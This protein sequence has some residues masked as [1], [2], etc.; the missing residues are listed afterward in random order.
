MGWRTATLISPGFKKRKVPRELLLDPPPRKRRWWIWVPFVA[1]CLTGLL[2]AIDAAAYEER[3]GESGAGRLYFKGD[4]AALH[5]KTKVA[6]KVTGLIVRTELTQAFTN[7]TDEW[8]EAV[9]VFPLPDTA[10]V[11]FMQMQIGERVITARVEEREQAKKI[12]EQAKAAR[13]ACPA[14]RPGHRSSRPAR[15]PGA[16]CGSRPRQSAP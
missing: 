5:L 8:Q 10:A 14:R 13:P 3:F 12:Y 16:R 15:A 2:F 6:I 4:G 11:N 1:L 9:Y 7:Q